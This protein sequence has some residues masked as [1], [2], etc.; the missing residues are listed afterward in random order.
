MSLACTNLFGEMPKRGH[1]RELCREK[2][3]MKTGTEE[4]GIVC[5]HVEWPLPS[6]QVAQ[7]S[8]PG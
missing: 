3:D 7:G 2:N 6:L 8:V 4:I 1:L 5:K